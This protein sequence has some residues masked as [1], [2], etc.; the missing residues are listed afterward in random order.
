MENNIFN[1]LAPPPPFY[2]GDDKLLLREHIRRHLK[3]IFHNTRKKEK[4][5]REE[6][7]QFVKNLG[8]DPNDNTA[9]EVLTQDLVICNHMSG[10]RI[11]NVND[12]DYL[13]PLQCFHFPENGWFYINHSTPSL[14][15]LTISKQNPTALF[16]KRGYITLS[17]G[18]SYEQVEKSLMLCCYIIL[19]AMKILAPK[20]VFTIKEF[21]LSNKVAAT[22]LVLQKIS[23]LRFLDSLRHYPSIIKFETVAKT[24]TSLHFDSSF[25]EESI[26][27]AYIKPLPTLKPRLNVNIAP[28]GGL[29]FSGFVYDYEL[30]GAAF[31]MA[32]LLKR[33][34]VHPDSLSPELIVEFMQQKR[35]AKQKNKEIKKRERQTK[36]NRW[37]ERVAAAERSA[38]ILDNRL[39]ELSQ[40]I[41]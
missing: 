4:E 20:E 38:T 21:K 10:C 41:E 30:E 5:F 14:T 1:S 13:F 17:G 34:R 7:R 18:S 19:D 28:T 32:Y 11:V 24:S 3:P 40:L 23:L 16:S 37:Y 2:I 33:F 35:E 6:V 29:V 22:T 31:V 25:D 8:F 15:I 39:K 9:P 26:N 27:M 36:M 12:P